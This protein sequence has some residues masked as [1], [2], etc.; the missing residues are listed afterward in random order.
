VE[1][2]IY[3]VIGFYLFLLLSW[4]GLNPLL[5]LQTAQGM[6]GRLDMR[7]G[8]STGMRWLLPLRVLAVAYMLGYSIVFI[9]YP[10]IQNAYLPITSLQDTRIAILG[11]IA[12]AFGTVILLLSRLQLVFPPAAE[13]P[14]D[15]SRLVTS[16]LYSFSRN[17]FYT[18]L[19][20][21]ILGIF[22]MIPDGLFLTSFLAL[23]FIQ[24]YRIIHLEEPY[25]SGLLGETY[26]GYCQRVG[27]YISILGRAS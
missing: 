23:V 3:V 15:H 26:V 18:G 17:P 12:T 8:I 21:A 22:L 13:F 10:E 24:H 14:A 7:E 16:G 19:Y 20:S 25:L 11:M 2:K 27:R 1:V 5:R 4:E 9:V 6:A